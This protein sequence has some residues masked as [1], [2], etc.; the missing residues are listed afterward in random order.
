MGKGSYF[1]YPPADLKIEDS[2]VIRMVSAKI[3]GKYNL[4]LIGE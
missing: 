1:K 2:V 4:I 3:Q